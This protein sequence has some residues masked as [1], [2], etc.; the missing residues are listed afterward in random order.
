MGKCTIDSDKIAFHPQWGMGWETTLNHADQYITMQRKVLGL[1]M[2]FKRKIPFNSI[3]K[4]FTRARPLRR[5]KAGAR[6][7]QMSKRPLHTLRE[8]WAF[9]FFITPAGGREVRI[10]T[11]KHSDPWPDIEAQLRR[12][13]GLEETAEHAVDTPPDISDMQDDAISWWGKPR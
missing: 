9:D 13:L 10:G 3:A 7:A 5:N 1:K 4:A 12:S 8:G 6:A 11:L 2:P